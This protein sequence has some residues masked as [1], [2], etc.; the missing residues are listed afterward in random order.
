MLCFA[1]LCFALLLVCW[2][3]ESKAWPLADQSLSL[4]ILELVQQANNYKQLKKGAN[5]GKARPVARILRHPS[6][7]AGLTVFCPAVLCCCGLVVVQRRK[8]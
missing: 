4:K 3:S 7:W 5:E 8:R 6:A 1:L 2:C